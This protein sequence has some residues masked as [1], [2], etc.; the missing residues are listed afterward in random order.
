MAFSNLFLISIVSIMYMSIG[1]TTVVNAWAVVNIAPPRM[2]TMASRHNNHPQSKTA[3]SQST[4]TSLLLSS[5]AATTTTTKESSVTELKKVLE[6]EYATFFNPMRTEYYAPNVSFDDPLTSLA[7]VDAY[8]AN[9]DML[10]GR[11]LL[12]SILFQ[13][14][15]INLHSITGGGCEIKTIVT[16]EHEKVEIQDII[17]RWTLR[18]TMKVLP[19]KPTARFSGISVYKI[20]SVGDGGGVQIVGQ[21]DYWDSINLKQGGGYEKVG[22]GEA[23]ADFLNQLKPG[24]F[25]AS[26]AA[27]ELPYSLLRRGKDYEVRKYPAFFAVQL[28]YERR[29]EG[30]GTLG[31]FTSGTETPMGPAIMEVRG[32][33]GGGGGGGGGGNN[34]KF[35]QWPLTYATPGSDTAPKPILA[36]EKKKKMTEGGDGGPWKTCEIVAVPAKVIA[37]AE[38]SDASLE[39]VVRKSA[40]QLR[41]SLERDGLACDV[42][43][44][45]VTFAQYDAIFSMGK[46][47]GEVWIELKDGGHPWC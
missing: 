1:I 20:K 9:V 40:R 30:F 47:R 4:T 25:Q 6:R 14:G 16:D 36:L 41:A 13:D 42:D 46:R 27:P 33:N 23:L 3:S 19:W 44:S 18:F 7:G 38:F 31:A 11:T 28:K 5:L 22:K 17:T 39:P 29:D 37:V 43:D 15:G 45:S 21:L 34:D 32:S 35:M 12:G 8:K 10:S 2:R 26:L 24:G